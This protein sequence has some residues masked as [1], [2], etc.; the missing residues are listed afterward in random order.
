MK[1]PTFL[2]TGLLAAFLAAPAAGMTPFC[3]FSTAP[4]GTIMGD[5]TYDLAAA[6]GEAD[7]V[8]VGRVTGRRRDGGQILTV[9]R[10]VKS[11]NAR[12]R[13]RLQA[14]EAE[15][16]AFKGIRLPRDRDFLLLLRLLPGG[17]FNKVDAG[18]SNACPNIFP[19][20]DGYA[21]IGSGAVALENLE[22]YFESGPEAIAFP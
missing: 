10:V 22:S 20:S 6:Y 5:A 16:A 19:V 14:L 4:D 18:G 2:L 1:R 11:S 7:C 12:A 17:E 9:S 15:G 13:M 21:R 3:R 8:V